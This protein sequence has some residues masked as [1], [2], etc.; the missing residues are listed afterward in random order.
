[1]LKLYLDV[2]PNF[3]PPVFLDVSLWCKVEPLVMT[4]TSYRDSFRQGRLG[5]HPQ[6]SLETHKDFVLLTVLV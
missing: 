5:A 2:Q 6:I 3:L 1:M 4:F